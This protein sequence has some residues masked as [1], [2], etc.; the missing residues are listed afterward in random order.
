V[1]VSVFGPAVVSGFVSASMSMS[2]S[3]WVWVLVWVWE[4]GWVGVDE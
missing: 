2:M 3:A 4:G 1:I